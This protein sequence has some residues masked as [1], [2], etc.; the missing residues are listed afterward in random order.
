MMDTLGVSMIIKDEPIERLAMMVEYLSPIVS[1]FSIVDTGS[2]DIAIDAPL[3]SSWPKV[4]LN[5]FLWCDDFAA[6]RNAT[7]DHLSTDWVLHLD[8][9]EMV[10]HEMYD[11]IVRIL[12]ECHPSTKGWL[13]L[14]QNYWGGEKGVIVEEHWHCRLF[15][16]ASGHW[17]KKLHEQVMLDG[18]PEHMT[19]WSMTLPKAHESA[20][21][22]HSKPRE[23]L[24]SSVQLYDRIG[25]S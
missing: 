19:R 13:F 10:S 14:T 25:E 1:E 2:K 5:H 17:Y 22:I 24:A 9:D 21:L 23:K 15:R 4:K 7:L 20:L 8:A 12:N 6:A 16:R 18:Q 3:I 11:S